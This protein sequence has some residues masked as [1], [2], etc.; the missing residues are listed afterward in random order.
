MYSIAMGYIVTNHDFFHC[1]ASL[2]SLISSRFIELMD[3]PWYY[4]LFE[5]WFGLG[6]NQH[7]S[8]TTRNILILLK[9]LQSWIPSDIISAAIKFNWKAVCTNH[10]TLFLHQCKKVYYLK[11]QIYPTNLTL[12]N[13]FITAAVYVFTYARYSLGTGFLDAVCV[14]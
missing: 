4:T 12:I 1:V 6:T 5:V 13:A 3:N 2:L 14:R 9:L 10:G 8:K 7:T 11:N